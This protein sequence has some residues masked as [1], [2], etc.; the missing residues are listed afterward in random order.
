MHPRREQMLI[1]C[2]HFFNQSK[3]PFKDSLLGQTKVCLLNNILSVETHEQVRVWCDLQN[4]TEVFGPTMNWDG[5][6]YVT[7]K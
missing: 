3:F 7:L 1:L 2:E 4:K 5:S 6:A